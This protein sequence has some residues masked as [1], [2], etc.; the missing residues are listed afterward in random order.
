M[1]VWE[2]T[3]LGLLQGATEFLPVSSSGHLVIGQL[4][5]GIEAPGVVLEV[6]LHLAT[7]FSVVWAYRERIGWLIRGALVLRP[8]AL[9]LVGLLAV[10][11]VPAAAVGFTAGRHVSA[12]FED[13]RVTGMALLVT[14]MVLWW[15]GRGGRTMASGETVEHGPAACGPSTGRADYARATLPTW[16]TAAVIGIAQALALVPGISRSGMTVATALRCGMGGREAAEFSFLMAIP[17]ILGAAVLNLPTA[18]SAAEEYGVA[19]VAP[20]AVGFV[21]ATVTGVL[22]IRTLV[23]ALKGGRLRWFA[24]YCW[25]VG[26]SF[27][28]WLAAS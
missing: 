1:T 14:G 20:L 23:A 9:R 15:G 22:A 24:P 19:F 16:R 2:A 11:S 26:C 5:W 18:L 12:L 28:V 6:T 7:L 25:V 4:A 17:A 27:L 10:A 3:A 8:D 21:V 13:A